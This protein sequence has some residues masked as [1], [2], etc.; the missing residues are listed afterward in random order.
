MS[1]G[2]GHVSAHPPLVTT[3]KQTEHLKEFRT[4]LTFLMPFHPGTHQHDKEPNSYTMTEYCEKSLDV[5]F[6]TVLR[7]FWETFTFQDV[8]TTER[9]TITHPCH[10]SHNKSQ[11]LP[12]LLFSLFYLV[13]H[14]FSVMYLVSHDPVCLWESLQSSSRQGVDQIHVI[15]HLLSANVIFAAMRWSYFTDNLIF[16]QNNSKKQAIGVGSD[17]NNM[18]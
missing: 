12:V 18:R 5:F 3:Y 16:F 10:V 7:C 2:I 6:Y 15:F 1:D 11:C 17:Y 4:Y 9:G 14:H 13:A 8:N